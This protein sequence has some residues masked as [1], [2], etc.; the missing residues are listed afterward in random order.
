[1]WLIV[2]ASSGFYRLIAAV[3][4]L[5]KTEKMNMKIVLQVCAEWI[6]TDFSDNPPG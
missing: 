2:T 1:M 6:K 4:T 5:V 3:R